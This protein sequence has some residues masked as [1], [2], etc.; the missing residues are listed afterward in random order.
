MV[1]CVPNFSEGRDRTIVAA[2]EQAVKSVPK[3][4]LLDSTSDVDHNRTVLTFAGDAAPVAEAA[5]AAAAAAVARIDLTKHEGVHPRVGAAD[6][7]PFVPVHGAT[8]QDC[9]GIAHMT[10]E[11]IW[12][13]LRVPVFLYEAAARRPGMRLE[14]VRKRA[15]IDLCAGH[16][17]GSSSNG[18][19][20]HS[21][22]A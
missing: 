13:E 22:R 10:G 3:A 15:G 4:L 16:W 8:L 11:R 18:R 1:E 9:V 2:L 20:L 12:R 7:V 17:R 5:F 19:I 6:V 14:S 21:G